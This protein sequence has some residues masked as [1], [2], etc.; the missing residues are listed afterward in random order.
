VSKQSPTTKFVLT[1]RPLPKVDGTKALCFVLK[2]LL[3]QYGLKC[4]ALHE[5]RIRDDAPAGSVP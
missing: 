3:R 1:L 4:V 2:R 5:K